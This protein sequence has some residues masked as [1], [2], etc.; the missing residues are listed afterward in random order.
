METNQEYI[1]VKDIISRFD[2]LKT[3][4]TELLT[5][6]LYAQDQIE[7]HKQA[8]TISSKQSNDK[9]LN[10]NN[11]LAKLRVRIEEIKRNSER[12]RGELDKQM[13]SASSKSL[14]L[15]QI[16][17]YFKLFNSRATN[18]LF[19]IVKGHLSNRLNTTTDPLLQMDSLGHFIADLTEIVNEKR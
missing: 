19:L 7:K 6:S 14:Q 15:G 8:F 17:M 16:K 11:Q 2:T 1:E 3:T 9:H 13:T 5:R 10:C 18:N 4:N 12:W